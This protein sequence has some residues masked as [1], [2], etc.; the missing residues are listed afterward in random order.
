MVIVC[1]YCG[2]TYANKYSLKKHQTVNAS[3]L[4]DRNKKV[5]TDKCE[6]C[7]KIYI[8]LNIHLKTCK[9]REFSISHNYEK[10]ELNGKI[11]KKDNK[12]KKLLSEIKELR[13]ENTKLKSANKHLDD[14]LREQQ[15][16]VKGMQT[17]PDKKTIYN[18]AIHPKLVNL[19]IGNI[20]ALTNEFIEERV[21]DGILTYERATRG[22]P[23]M[24]EVICELITHENDNG[25]IERNY[26]CTDVSRNSFHR[27][28]ESKKWKSDKGGRYLNAMLDRFIDQMDE[29]KTKAYDVYKNTPHDSMEW[30]QV[31]WERK[32]ISRLYS[33]V[34][35]KEGT[36]D[37][38]DLINA[39]RKEI[40]KRASV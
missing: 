38:E 28:L 2:K 7:G 10:E 15:G 3:C 21:S 40:A 36:G 35:C 37:R 12:I 23:G 8:H 14:K 34:V 24:L 20:R 22:Y 5:V 39:L 6:Y 32:N 27:L 11:D 17:A 13:K 31:D 19:P 29:Y 4:R 16:I 9:T 26:V 1:D 30:S 18:T 33:G 25:E